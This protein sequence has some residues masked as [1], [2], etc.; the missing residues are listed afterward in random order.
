MHVFGIRNMSTAKENGWQ[1]VLSK[2]SFF[3]GMARLIIFPNSNLLCCSEMQVSADGLLCCTISNDESVKVYDVVNYDMMVM[4]R[5]PFFPGAVEWVYKQ[6]DA[7][8]KLAIS[9]R[10]FS[11]VHIYDV[12]SGSNEPIVSYQ[13]LVLV[14]LL[15]VLFLYEV[16]H[17]LFVCSFF[18]IEN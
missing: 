5:L 17:F 14:P 16:V 9:D 15:V 8:A 4:M 2:Y 13:V 11:Y 1:L 3:Y 18:I 6:G 12:R 7:K 10:N